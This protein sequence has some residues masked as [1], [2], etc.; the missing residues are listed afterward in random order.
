MSTLAEIWFLR[1]LDHR[2]QLV[3]V[4]GP[5]FQR[6]THRLVDARLPSSTLDLDLDDA[7]RMTALPREGIVRRKPE[8]Q[9]SGGVEC[10]EVDVA[11]GHEGNP[12]V[13][14]EKGGPG[15]G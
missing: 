8:V 7:Q 2:L 5:V 11:A 12:E 14:R 1:S 15:G 3:E 4:T 10:D 6:I 9:L 13:A